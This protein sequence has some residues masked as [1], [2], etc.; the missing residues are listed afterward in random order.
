MVEGSNWLWRADLG[1]DTPADEVATL[2]IESILREGGT[3]IETSDGQPAKVGL[4][5][6]V[7]HS[8]MAS[9]AEHLF[10]LS[11]TIMANAGRHREAELLRQAAM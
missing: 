2:A 10:V 9:V 5:M 1:D 7:S 3:G 6:M 11:S 8:G 4:V